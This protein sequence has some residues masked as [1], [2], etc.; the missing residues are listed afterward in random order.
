M[1]PGRRVP[2][3]GS[4]MEPNVAE[5]EADRTLRLMD[6]TLLLLL[7]TGETALLLLILSP[8]GVDDL[9]QPFTGDCLPPTGRSPPLPLQ[10]I[11]G[12]GAR[13]PGR[14]RR[15]G[16]PSQPG[17]TDGA[18]RQLGLSHGSTRPMRPGRRVPRRGSSIEP[19]SERVT[20]RAARDA[21]E[22]AG[23]NDRMGIALGEAG[24]RAKGRGEGRRGEAVPSSRCAAASGGLAG[25]LELSE[26][27][28]RLPTVSSMSR[29]TEP[30]SPVG[31][32]G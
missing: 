12:G 31:C 14:H 9:M 19:I 4:S 25:R 2:F 7:G 30:K 5:G 15:S 28:A 26:P 6:N 1:A 21:R 13:P 20:D 10:R 29:S 27:P 17:G 8:E 3:R 23:L 32:C 24:G 18:E 16:L 22:S 11:P